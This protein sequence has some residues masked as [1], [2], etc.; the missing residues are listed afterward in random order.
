[1]PTHRQSPPMND[2]MKD[3]DTLRRLMPN[4]MRDAE[5]ETPLPEKMTPYLDAAAEW[6]A[7]NVTGEAGA[8]AA[9]ESGVPDAASRAV[10]CEAWRRA[11]P[12]LDLVL[13]ANGFAVAGN[14]NLTP[15][16]RQRVDTLLASL[17]AERDEALATLLKTL[18]AVPGWRDSRQGRWFAATLFQDLDVVG[19]TGVSSHAWDEYRHLRARIMDIES[20]LAEDWMS[21]ELMESLRAGI[22][23][24]SMSKERATLVKTLKGQILAVLTGGSFSSRRLT[25]AVNFIRR[26][27]DEFGEWHD[28]HVAELFMPP[29]FRNDKSAGGYFF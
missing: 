12:A 20:S 28:S 25:E 17:E 3:L 18:P 22:A 21:E 2:L 27:P 24:G 13:T 23:R 15:A 10:A 4:C 26:N 7:R 1:M 14:Q 29:K 16:S 11:L 5:G 6:L 9:P 8:M 19:Q